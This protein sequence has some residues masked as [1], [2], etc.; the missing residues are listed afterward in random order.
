[1]ENATLHLLR[2]QLVCATI[3][4]IT[5]NDLT[6]ALKDLMKESNLYKKTHCK[7]R[8]FP[9]LSVISNPLSTSAKE[10]VGLRCRSW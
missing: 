6:K 7:I 3:E 4:N 2:E 9:Y 10:F 8:T 1:V 5:I